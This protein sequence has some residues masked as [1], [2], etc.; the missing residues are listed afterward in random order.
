MHNLDGHN[1]KRKSIIFS[2]DS[3]FIQTPISKIAFHCLNSILGNEHG[4]DKCNREY[5]DCLCHYSPN[6]TELE[7]MKSFQQSLL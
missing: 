7:N 5:C 1:K 4:H 2:S 6:S 3:I